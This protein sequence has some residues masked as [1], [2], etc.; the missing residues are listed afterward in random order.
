M[1]GC[2]PYSNVRY[3]DPQSIGYVRYSIRIVNQIQT[4][5]LLAL[6][7]K[8]FTQVKRLQFNYLLQHLD[9]F[10]AQSVG[11]EGAISHLQSKAKFFKGNK[12]DLE[13][14]REF[15]KSATPKPN[16]I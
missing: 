6:V 16:V 8:I 5:E 3:S 12:T 13:V 15:K 11:L 10:N 1:F 9:R 7:G 2:F 4:T 14:L